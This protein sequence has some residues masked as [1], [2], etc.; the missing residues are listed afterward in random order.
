MPA[1]RGRS[2][3]GLLTAS[4]AVAGL[5]SSTRLL[6]SGAYV[7]LWDFLWYSRPLPSFLGILFF[8]ASLA[9]G[10]RF[11]YPYAAGALLLAYSLSGIITDDVHVLYV[12]AGPSAGLLLWNLQWSA[13]NMPEAIPT[14]VAIDVAARMA[15]G[16]LEPW[17]HPVVSVAYGLALAYASL[18]LMLLDLYE[19]PGSASIVWLSI[20]EIGAVYPNAALHYS[21]VHDYGPLAF[22]GASLLVVAGYSAGLLLPRLI[23]VTSLAISGILAVLGF[24]GGPLW[25]ALAGFGTTSI[26]NGSRPGGSYL[27]RLLFGLFFVILMVAG[28]GV[29]AYPYLGLWPLADMLEIVV[30][31]ATLPGI[32][33][34]LLQPRNQV[35]P[36]RR[37]APIIVGALILGFIALSVQAG[38]PP[39]VEDSY[40]LVSY[41]LHQGYTWDGRLN[42]WEAANY[43][44]QYPGLIA[45]L[46]EVDAGRLTSAYMDLPL[47]LRL[48]G[49]QVAYQPAIE[50]T[51]GVAVA[52]G[53]PVGYS[54]GYLLPSTGEQRAAIKVETG[55][56]VVVSA[57][58]GLEPS[59]RAMQA[60]RLLEIASTTP[61]AHAICG[62][63]NEQ[64]GDAIEIITQEYKLIPSPGEMPTCCL[65][66]ELNQTIDYIAYKP[67][68][69]IILSYKIEHTDISD[70]LPV[71]A[72]AQKKTTP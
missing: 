65:G 19:S 66:E 35:A 57:H 44:A 53:F 16:G 25:A 14:G 33:I 54:S 29:Y 60:S 2:R 12:L 40:T 6:V 47:A 10:P 32:A 58:L 7:S 69:L 49:L 36:A 70:H 68:K 41:N 4:L 59:E 28:V 13:R 22:A 18:S 34:G 52:S 9:V 64:K 1:A 71:I 38:H 72:K 45:C 63:L 61:K 46:Q 3:V 31:T 67:D 23:G 37:I 48:R 42:G 8:L 26:L 24:L 50:G 17:D 11:L 56:L 27:G 20:A 43:L 62:D 55:G 21:G 5:L 51:Y 30:F 39:A 15:A